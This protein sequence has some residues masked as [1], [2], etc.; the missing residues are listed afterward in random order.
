MTREELKQAWEITKDAL[1]I[2]QEAHREAVDAMEVATIEYH[3][4]VNRW[5]KNVGV[6]TDDT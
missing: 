3:D 1:A 2:A 6:H 4:A 5:L